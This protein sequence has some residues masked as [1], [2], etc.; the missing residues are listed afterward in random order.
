MKSNKSVRESRH[1][2]G[3]RRF[4]VYGGRGVI[5]RGVKG[6]RSQGRLI[7]RVHDLKIQYEIM[8]EEVGKI[9][10]NQ[11]KWIRALL[12]TNYPY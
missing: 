12:T 7:K 10:V 4:L 6:N 2:E 5:I 9:S 1:V 3:K 11:V 8:I